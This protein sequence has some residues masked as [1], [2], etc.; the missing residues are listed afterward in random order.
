MA[1][2]SR[3]GQINLAMSESCFTVP[4]TTGQ[5]VYSLFQEPSLPDQAATSCALF[6]QSLVVLGSAEEREEIAHEIGLTLA[7]P[8]HDT[9][10]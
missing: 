8:A 1:M 6:A 2:M 7:D 5:K 9:R 10:F 3:T 4:F